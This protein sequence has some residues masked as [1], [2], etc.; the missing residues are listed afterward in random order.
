[1]RRQVIYIASPYS[2][3]DTARNVRT[4]VDATDRIIS[5]G[6]TPFTPLLDHFIHLI[7]PRS[8]ESWMVDYC[9][10]WVERCDLILRLPGESPGADR[11]VA[12][13]LRHGK[14]PCFGW[15]DLNAALQEL[16]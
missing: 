12:H 5:M 3:G 16:E 11:E 2:L 7:H 14:E 9:L 1:M 8:D 6:H 10:P 15:D 13:A 4:Q